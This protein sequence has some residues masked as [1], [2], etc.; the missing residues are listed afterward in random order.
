MHERNLFKRISLCNYEGWQVPRSTIG[1]LEIR[2]TSGRVL[3]QNSAG[4]RLKKSWC[5][6]SSTKTGR[7]TVVPTQDSQAREISSYL[8]EVRIFFFFFLFRS[9]LI[10]WNLLTLERATYFT[11]M[12]FWCLPIIQPVAYLLKTRYKYKYISSSNIRFKTEHKG[13]KRCFVN[14]LRSCACMYLLYVINM[15]WF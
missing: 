7:K 4:L 12:L 6:S 11:Q 2:R 15:Q 10:G 8:Q 5:F 3:V 13:N 9:L 1:K 14:L